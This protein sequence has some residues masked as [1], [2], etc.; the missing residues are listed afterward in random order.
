MKSV[1]TDG[2]E[3]VW[4]IYS[5]QGSSK[6]IYDQLIVFKRLG[7]VYDKVGKGGTWIVLQ[8]NWVKGY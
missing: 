7:D 1:D 4:N 8:L 5:C 2:A 6:K 3:D